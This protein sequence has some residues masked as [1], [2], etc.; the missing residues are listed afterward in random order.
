[1]A[2]TRITKGVIKPNE[3]YDTNNINSTGIVTAIGLDINGNG[4]VSGNLSVG[5][6]LTYEDVTSIDSVGI[7]TARDGIHVGAGVSAVGVGTFGSLDIGGDIDVDG[8][9]NLDN[10]SVAGVTTFASSIQVADSIIHEG[11]T[12]TKIHF[13][14]NRIKLTVGNK[15]RVDSGVSNYTTIYGST[16][17]TPTSSVPKGSGGY[18]ARFRDEDGDDTIVRFHNTNVK[19]TVLEWSDFGNSTTAGNLVFKGFVN[20]VEGGRFDGSG[21][22]KLNQ[23]LDVDGHTNLDNVNVVGVV[24]ASAGFRVPDGNYNT[25]LISVGSQ[26]DFIIYHDT[27][28]TYAENKVGDFRLKADTIKIQSRTG[29]ENFIHANLNGAVELYHNNVKKFET[30]SNGASVS[31]IQNNQG[32]DLNGVGN[33]TCIRFMST[34]SSPAHAYRIAYH[35]LTNFIY[36]S[37]ALTFDKTDTSGNFDSHIA[38]ISDGGFHLADNKKL[39]V[40]D[41]SSASGDLQIYHDGTNS[42]LKNNTGVLN[43][44]GDDTRFLND[45]GNEKLR[46]KSNGTVNIGTNNQASGDSSSK[47][48]VGTASGSD[49]GIAVIGNAD[50]TT[51]ALV[52]TNWDGTQ[53][54][55][56]SFIHF[57]NSGWGS[58]QIGSLAG[59]DG[60]GIYDDSVLRMSINNVGD[61]TFHSTGHI[62]LPSG[63]TAQRVNTTGA[64][65]YNSS[66]GNLEFYDGASWKRVR[67]L[68]SAPTNGLLAYW[69][70]STASRSGTI[71]N[72][73]SGNNHHLNVNGTITDDTSETKFN[74]CIDFGTADGNHYLKSSSNSFTDIDASSGFTGVSISVWVRTGNSTQNQWIISEGT[75]N[76]RWAFFNESANAPKWRSI[77]GG[78]I[79]QTGTILDDVWHHLVVTYN[80]SNNLV[81]HYRDGSFI[82]SG[83]TTNPSFNGEYLLVGQHSSLLGNTSSYRW[84]GKMAHMRIYNRV[85]TSSEVST[86]YQ[87]W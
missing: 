64:L 75:V 41:K 11:D 57:D 52:I 34:G 85:L 20:G 40:G 81:Q 5:G 21:N 65:R 31:N 19:N 48:R 82:N 9:T 46:I 38:G 36:G 1:M 79:I 67:L 33:N 27:A 10:V 78:D 71:Y 12:D 35:S 7:I 53:T 26:E 29:V 59:S 44:Q 25:N 42:Y 43:V 74:G 58:H 56:K 32:L 17:F 8:H 39:H 77:N 47:L 60:F 68:E 6:V 87:Q 49:V 69:P 84:R 3:N 86:L 15:L 54:Q 30:T 22:F 16:N 24:T 45:A 50:T 61:T 2:L 55:N 18:V 28:H 63:T 23:D 37:P 72:D 80:S 76:T 62:V 66:L 70:F 4:D 13:D 14:N 73:Q 51:P 83:T